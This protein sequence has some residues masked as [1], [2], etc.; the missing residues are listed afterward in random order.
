MNVAGI[1][2]SCAL[3]I[4]TVHSASL[5]HVVN[6]QSNQQIHSD[7]RAHRTKRT[8]HVSPRRFNRIAAIVLTQ[9]LY[10]SHQVISTLVFGL[11]GEILKASFIAKKR[12]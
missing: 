7:S 2:L 6:R 5:T 1:L 8:V 3:W 11:K 12:R 4:T 9:G 10:E